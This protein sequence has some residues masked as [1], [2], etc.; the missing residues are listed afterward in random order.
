MLT[1]EDL[2]QIAEIV[3][4]ATDGLATK[5]EM[6]PLAT[7]DDIKY[8]K[9]EMHQRFNVV[10]HDLSIVLNFAEGQDAELKEQVDDHEKRIKKLE[11]PPAV[12]H[13]IK[14]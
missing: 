13:S 8:L 9:A 7:T 11:S 5:E 1:S 14:R 3:S 10:D 6:K 12:T 4:R 2:K